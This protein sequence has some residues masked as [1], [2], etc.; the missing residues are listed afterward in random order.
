MKFSCD[1]AALV[2]AIG[3]V[4]RAV[5]SKSSLPALEGILLRADDGEL[6]LS[7][8]NL[9]L[10]IWTVLTANIAEPGSVV[11]GAKFFGDI[12]RRLPG[13]MVTVEVDEKSV[14]TI[15]SGKAEFSLIGIPGEEFP[16]LPSLREGNHFTIER[17]LL[18][19]MIRQTLF[20]VGVGEVRP[21]WTGTLFEMKEN[22]IRLVSV[23]GYRLAL[24][25]EAVRG[26]N[27]GN[28]IVPGKTLGEL[29]KF[30]VE[31]E[32]DVQLVAG[33]KHV[34]FEIGDYT[35][36]SRLIEGEFV[37]YASAIPQTE[38][39]VVK[40]RVAELIESVERASVL[41][42]ERLRSPI[43][44]AVRDD[45]IRVSCITAQG[46]VFDEVS[47]LEKTGEDVEICFNNKYLLD[48]LRAV[49]SDEV[50]LTFSGNVA[51]LKVQPV[52]G[53]SFIFVVVPVAPKG[54]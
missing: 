17:E 11:L 35:I 19:S 24:R 29:E 40:A 16:E 43:R 34:L 28:F 25:E 9:E 42:S 39:T 6:T 49:E 26:G 3:N 31:G 47:F 1:R 10:G 30:L 18:R 41:I 23:D 50:R 14:A 44:L 53:D 7:G 5:S 33:K 8:Y 37:D 21:I 54:R 13:D 48:A 36:I 22:R 46:K 2:A 12:C 51:P 4:S 20:A 15:K 45:G 38:K 32:E 52:E 27:E